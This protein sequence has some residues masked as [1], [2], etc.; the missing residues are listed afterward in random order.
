MRRSQKR[1]LMLLAALPLLVVASGLVYQVAMKTFEGQAPGFWDGL[2]WASGT[3]TTNGSAADRLVRHPGMVLY[4]MGI[5]F[6]GVFL[7]Y[8]VFPIYVVPYLDERFQARLPRDTVHDLSDHAVIFRYGPAVETLLDELA[9]AKVATLVLEPDETVARRLLEMKQR[10]LF[11]GLDDDAL[12]A[13]RLDRARALIANGSDDENAAII[14]AAR[15]LGF[16]GTVLGLV[17]EPLHRRPMML[18]GANAVFTPRHI[19]GAALA[20]R[21]SV[22][23]SPRVAG[24]QQLGRRLEIAEVRVRADSSLAGQAMATVQVAHQTGATI[25]GQWLGGELVTS[26]DPAARIEADGILVAA[27]NHASIERLTELAGGQTALRRKGHFVVG[28]FGEVGRKVVEL[29]RTVG[30]EV[31][32]IERKAGEGIDVVGNVLDAPVLEA[33][34]VRQAQ[35]VILALDTDSATLFATVILR[36]LV[37]EVPIIARVNQAHNVERIH[38]AGAYFALSISQISGQML[39]KKLLGEEAFAIDTNLK[40]LK[41]RAES[42][43]TGTHPAQLRIPDRTGCSVVAVER[44]DEVLVELAPEF[45]LASGD[46]VYVC[47]SIASVRRFNDVFRP[48]SV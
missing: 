4:V 26:S 37:P 29:L 25:V 6:I 33:A 44:G 15:Q 27:G 41:V 42:L 1:L 18:A 28:G 45:R 40:I 30:E 19:L 5:Q 12:T 20:A 35:A 7:V 31:R 47:G 16:K 46:V 38:R 13:A 34:G 22:H 21:A 2:G 17:E 9:A 11:R 24:V 8:L 36:D 10:V 23:I 32:V 39:A 43:T 3:L 48:A 14:L